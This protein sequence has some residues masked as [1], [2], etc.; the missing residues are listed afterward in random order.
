[1]SNQRHKT[2]EKLMAATRDRIPGAAV[3]WL[4]AVREP[5]EI[6][7]MAAVSP[8]V[9]DEQF[10][11]LVESFS[12]SLPGLMGKMDHGALA[13]L[14]EGGMGA[15]MANGLTAR[16]PNE[17]KRAKLPWEGDVY[18]AAQKRRKNGQ[19]GEG[20]G[21]PS[22]KQQRRK[23]TR[24]EKIAAAEKEKA[25]T[26]D[27]VMEAAVARYRAGVTVKSPTGNDVTFGK[28]AADHLA[29][30]EGARARFADLAEKTV[31]APDA[32]FREGLRNRYI[33]L[34]V[35]GGR[36]SFLVVTTQVSERG[37]DVITF[38]KQSPN[39]A[40]PPGKRIYPAD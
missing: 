6:L 34:P 40:N 5:L 35:K 14:M 31:A 19:F 24:K 28:R 10:L 15:A 9:S 13:E 1:M 8:D 18:L 29:Q 12:E 30:K 3:R 17:E 39:K 22:H 26:P 27:P 2:G 7:T 11:E 20:D 33:K 36:S 38:T 16:N 25:A 4:A 21:V 23:P 37:E 32:V